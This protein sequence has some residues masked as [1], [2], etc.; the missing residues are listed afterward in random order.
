M[1]YY[2]FKCNLGQSKC[3]HQTTEAPIL[4]SAVRHD[5]P[6]INQWMKKLY[7]NNPAFKDTTDFDRELHSYFCAIEYC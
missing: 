2:H 3:F 6:N 4:T 1:Y 7:W 5:Y